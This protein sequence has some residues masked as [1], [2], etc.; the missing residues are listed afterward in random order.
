MKFWQEPGFK[1]YTDEMRAWLRGYQPT[2]AILDSAPKTGLPI[3][4]KAALAERKRRKAGGITNTEFGAKAP[5][6]I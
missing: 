5:N 6:W 1:F 4:S 2:G 3:N